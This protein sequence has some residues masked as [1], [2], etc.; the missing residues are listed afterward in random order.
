M[1]LWVDGS[2][3]LTGGNCIVVLGESDCMCW[4]DVGEMLREN[5]EWYKEKMLYAQKLINNSSIKSSLRRSNK[6][7]LLSHKFKWIS[8]IE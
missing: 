3:C 4:V 5:K 8:I 1:T 6:V 7:R 2:K